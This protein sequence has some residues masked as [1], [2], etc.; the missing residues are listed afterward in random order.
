MP[1]GKYK[2]KPPHDFT[3][4]LSGWL[5]W[6]IVR[7]LSAGEDAEKLDHSYVFGGNVR[8]TLKTV[9]NFFKNSIC[10]HH[11]TQQLYVWALIPDKWKLIA[12]QKPVTNLILKH[13]LTSHRL[14]RSVNADAG[15]DLHPA[16]RLVTPP[17]SILSEMASK[18]CLPLMHKWLLE[19]LCRERFGDL[20]IPRSAERFP[21]N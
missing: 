9:A 3:A 13:P 18:F 19:I 15:A 7:T 6:K 2:G 5:K 1:R 12:I 21:I 11:I 17:L 14:H 10:K 4:H 16:L 8:A 20:R